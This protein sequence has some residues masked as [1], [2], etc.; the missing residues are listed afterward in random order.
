MLADLGAEAPEARIANLET[1]ITASAK[2]APK[3][4]NYRMHPANVGCLQAANLDCCALANNHVLDWGDEGLIETLSTLKQAGIPF[5]GAGQNAEEAAA[6]AILDRGAGARLLVFSYGSPTSGIPS[7]WAAKPQRPGVN[8]VPD[9]S[10]ATAERIGERILA[11][12]R[13]GDL[14]I[15]SIHWGSNWGYKVEDD[16]RAF[17]HALIEAGACDVLHGHSSHHPRPLEVHRGRLVLYGCGDF[18]NDYE[19]IGGYERYRGD[20]VLAY[21]PRLSGEGT[22][23]RLTLLAYRIR[24]FRLERAAGEDASWL[25]ATLDRE[26][27]PFGARVRHGGDHRLAVRW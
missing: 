19:G 13:P 22:L 4:I 11:V 8:L 23:R 15:V 9:L 6:P 2:P 7:S 25:A 27:R 17:A 10:A 24:R 20:L 12:R 1:S 26:S 5:A 18:L 14:V 3:G 16:Q 21:L